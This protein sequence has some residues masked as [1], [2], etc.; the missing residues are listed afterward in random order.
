MKTGVPTPKNR[1][2]AIPAERALSMN[3]GGPTVT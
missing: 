1:F 2:L 3:A